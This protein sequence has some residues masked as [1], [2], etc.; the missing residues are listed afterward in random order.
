M[1]SKILLETKVLLRR[2]TTII[3]ILFPLVVIAATIVSIFNPNFIQ[4]TGTDISAI[5]YIG[6]LMKILF[7]VFVPVALIAHMASITFREQYEKAHITLYKTLDNKKLILVKLCSLYIV[8]FLY[9]ISAFVSLM[10]SYYLSSIAAEPGIISLKLMDK[11]FMNEVAGI[12]LIMLKGMIII[13]L[14]SL[15]SF[16]VSSTVNIVVITMYTQASNFQDKL[17]IFKYL[18]VDFIFSGSNDMVNMGLGLL[19][20]FLVAFVTTFS[21]YRLMV[22]KEY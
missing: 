18:F 7:S 13:Q 4:I 21:S 12:F 1:F 17:G 6:L 5:S 16:F 22:R 19:F 9:I 20:W 8:L 2:R 3:L 14:A 15:L 10:I 11:M